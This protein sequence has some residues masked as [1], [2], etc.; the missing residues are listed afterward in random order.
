MGLINPVLP[1][2]GQ[3]R[4]AEEVDVLNA[5][6]AILNLVN[7]NI[8]Q[9]N[10]AADGVGP[11]EMLGHGAIVTSLPVAPVDGQECFFLADGATGI[12]WHLRFR[13]ASP[14]T[15]KWE[16]VGGRPLRAEV[17]TSETHPTALGD[18]A[19]VGPSLV[20]P[21]AGV[22]DYAWGS[23]VTHS[24]GGPSK[25]VAMPVFGAGFVAAG[26]EVSEVVTY[27]GF[28]NAFEMSNTYALRGGAVAVSD[29]VRLR[30]SIQANVAPTTPL[31]AKRWLAMLPVRVG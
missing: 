19:T 20:T 6:T 14:N 23:E 1:T 13:A 29:P 26:R 5:V 11:T 31:V 9:A 10:I 3:P 7:G 24:G 2:V 16:Y 15:H 25:F 22:Y 17:A 8:D 28:I 21:L 30:Y 12:V 27:P 18:A 4:G